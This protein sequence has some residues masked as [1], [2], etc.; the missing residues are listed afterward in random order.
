MKPAMTK[1]SD[2]VYW[3]RRNPTYGECRLSAPT[4]HMDNGM[5]M[6]H[7][8]KTAPTVCCADGWDGEPTVQQKIANA[9][10]AAQ[11][12]SLDSMDS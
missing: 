3:I 6:T 4:V 5:A 10:F 9:Y 1:C 7:F 8:P 12:G 11:P 2:C